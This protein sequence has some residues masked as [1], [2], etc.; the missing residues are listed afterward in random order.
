[1]LA[2]QGPRSAAVL[3]AVGLPGELGYMAFADTL[4]SGGDEVTV[5]LWGPK[6]GAWQRFDPPLKQAAAPQPSPEEMPT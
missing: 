6:D 4:G 1:M 2:L 3:A 5:A